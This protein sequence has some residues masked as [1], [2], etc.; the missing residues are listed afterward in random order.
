MELKKNNSI[1]R[2]I[3][4]TAFIKKDLNQSQINIARKI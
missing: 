1:Y 3:K 2:I 4:N